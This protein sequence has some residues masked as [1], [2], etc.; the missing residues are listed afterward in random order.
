M[1]ERAKRTKDSL[2]IIVSSY[3]QCDGKEVYS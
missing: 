3:E 1:N 2:E